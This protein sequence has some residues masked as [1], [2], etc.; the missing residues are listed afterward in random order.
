MD[1]INFGIWGL[2]AQ[3]VVLAATN[4]FTFFFTRRRYNSEVES[5]DLDNVRKTLDIYKG[6]IDDLETRLGRMAERINELERDL[7]ELKKENNKLKDDFCSGPDDCK[8]KN[9]NE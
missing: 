2:I 9:K 5:T 1:N 6:I 7:D 3:I 4:F 8:Y